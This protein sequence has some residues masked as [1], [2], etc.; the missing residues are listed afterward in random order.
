ME[1]KRKE[2]KQLLKELELFPDLS[3]RFYILIDANE[4]S[5]LPRAALL[6]HGPRS[7]RICVVTGM[8]LCLIWLPTRELYPVR[9]TG[10][11]SER[12]TDAYPLQ[13]PSF[14]IRL[15]TSWAGRKQVCPFYGRRVPGS[16]HDSRR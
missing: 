6:S 4:N 14:I 13:S 12:E 9:G 15:L 3:K 8:S 2:P 11:G 16:L 7:G 1:L 10:S 5:G